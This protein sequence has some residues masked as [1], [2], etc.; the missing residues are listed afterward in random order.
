[1]QFLLYFTRT[2]LLSC[3]IYCLNSIILG[4]Y[5][6]VE[7]VN[8]DRNGLANYDSYVRPRRCSRVAREIIISGRSNRYCTRTSAAA[9]TPSQS[10]FH[11]PFVQFFADGF[12]C[13]LKNLRFKPRRVVN[14]RAA[15][16]LFV[17]YDEKAEFATFKTMTVYLSSGEV[18][19]L[20]SNTHRGFTQKS[21]PIT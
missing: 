15:R 16:V 9:R 7:S 2:K 19:S 8:A 4:K 11:G 14:E 18:H 1:M 3:F 21:T 20:M 13:A 12:Y 10:F 17:W 5:R 6:R